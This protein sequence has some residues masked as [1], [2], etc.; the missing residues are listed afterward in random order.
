MTRHKVLF[1][2][3]IGYFCHDERMSKASD[4]MSYYFF[5]SRLIKGVG[6]S[7]VVV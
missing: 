2:R 7:Y 4:I 5:D 1:S 3:Y 6:G